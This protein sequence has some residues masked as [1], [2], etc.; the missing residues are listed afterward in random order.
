MAPN[1]KSKEVVAPVPYCFWP[2]I[3]D[4]EGEMSEII[5]MVK[6]PVLSCLDV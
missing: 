4:Y 6:L 2:K 5:V 1:Q 3:L